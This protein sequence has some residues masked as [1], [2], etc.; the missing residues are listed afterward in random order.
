M[1]QS[2]TINVH[3]GIGASFRGTLYE[4][5]FAGKGEEGVPRALKRDGG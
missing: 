4:D 2:N 1:Q 5:V 3:C